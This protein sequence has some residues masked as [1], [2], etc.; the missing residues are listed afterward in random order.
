MY[1]SSYRNEQLELSKLLN[2]DEVWTHEKLKPDQRRLKTE[3]V[4][5]EI[6]Y[7]TMA[8]LN[9]P[10]ILKCTKVEVSRPK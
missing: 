10:E 9:R 7:S 5:T 2:Q 3:G 6:L 4:L 1:S 8:R